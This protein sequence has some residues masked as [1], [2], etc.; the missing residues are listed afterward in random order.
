M[1][2]QMEKTQTAEKKAEN[3]LLLFAKVQT[4]LLAVLVLLL[5]VGG[6]FAAV[7]VNKVMG[8]VNSLD[9]DRINAAVQSLSNTAAELEKLDMEGV[10]K[11]VEALRG[12]AQKLADADIDAVNGGIEALTDA[13]GNLQDLDI[14]KLNDL[15]TALEKTAAQMEKTSAAFGKLFGK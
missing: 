5:V 14:E 11:T 13:A 12:A 3:Q 4:A 6:I 9:M 8:V 15:I 10:G 7:Q 1:E 2:Q